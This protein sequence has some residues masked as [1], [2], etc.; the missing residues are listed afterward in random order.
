MGTAKDD[1]NAQSRP[2]TAGTESD[3]ALDDADYVCIFHY[4][5]SKW[6]GSILVVFHFNWYYYAVFCDWL[7][8]I[9]DTEGWRGR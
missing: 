7:G 6:S 2:Q 8:R 9:G 5:L 3:D 4:D 1:V